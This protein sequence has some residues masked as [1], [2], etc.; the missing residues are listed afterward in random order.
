MALNTKE[1]IGNFIGWKQFR[2]F[3][4]EG[5]LEGLTVTL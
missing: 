3:K 5:L 4:E 1:K 2:K